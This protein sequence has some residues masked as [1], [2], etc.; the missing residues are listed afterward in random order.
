MAMLAALTA[1]AG[2]TSGI[3]RAWDEIGQSLE[4]LSLSRP[5]I[6]G[7]PGWMA[8]GLTLLALLGILVLSNSG[9][10]AALPFGLAAL[11]FGVMLTPM[12]LPA[13]LLYLGASA[14]SLLVD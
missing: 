3:W 1:L 12:A 14:F 4:L 7:A 8:V 13:A 9:R 6:E 2:V 5:L 10:L 11:G